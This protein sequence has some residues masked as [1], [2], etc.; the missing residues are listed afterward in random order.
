MMTNENTPKLLPCPF[1]GGDAEFERLGTRMQS[2]IV[3]CQCCGATQEC[4]LTY[5]YGDVWNTRTAPT[6]DT[7]VIISREV[8]ELMKQTTDFKTDYMQGNEQ[9]RN[10]LI[11]I[12]LEYEF[13]ND[14]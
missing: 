10:D 7:H 2:T 1:C 3:A 9:G 5:D 11:D 13:E 4:G 12:L 8:L 14:K 6:S